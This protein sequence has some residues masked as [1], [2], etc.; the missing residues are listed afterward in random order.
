MTPDTVVFLSE[1]YNGLLKTD[2]DQRSLEPDYAKQINLKFLVNIFL[3][4]Q[5]I[6]IP[7]AR[8]MFSFDL[9]GTNIFSSSLRLCF[10]VSLLYNTSSVH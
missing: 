8:E 5:T 2:E 9:E 3:N 6:V 10:F 7:L 4:M 1:I